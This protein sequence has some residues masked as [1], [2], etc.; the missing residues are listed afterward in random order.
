MGSCYSSLQRLRHLLLDAMSATRSHSSEWRKGEV[1]SDHRPI[2]P[3][4]GGANHT[5]IHCF[6]E[7]EFGGAWILLQTEKWWPCY[8]VGFHSSS[9]TENASWSNKVLN[10]RTIRSGKPYHCIT[11]IECAGLQ[12]RRAAGSTP[13][14]LHKSLKGWF[15]ATPS[16][17][18]PQQSQQSA[19]E[20][21]CALWA[22]TFWKG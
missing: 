12:R 16:F 22:S 3:C 17:C 20:E 18:S 19:W 13:L 21:N 4:P 2:D 9:H 5:P 14:L 10:F 6:W 11:L 15:P 1:G 8:F 7:R